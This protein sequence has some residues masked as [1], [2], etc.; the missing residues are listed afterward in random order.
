[1]INVIVEFV[2]I[3][4]KCCLT[5]LHPPSPS[6]S[7]SSFLFS[8]SLLL[9]KHN[10]THLITTKS[11]KRQTLSTVV[12]LCAL[13]PPSFLPSL[14]NHRWKVFCSSLSEDWVNVTSRVQFIG[15]IDILR[16]LLLSPFTFPFFLTP[17]RFPELVSLLITQ[18]KQEVELSVLQQEVC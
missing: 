1:M 10:L 18:P 14:H 17:T 3:G 13:V 2:S 16:L 11:L 7:T 8:L 6:P 5:S 12:T 15:G 4:F 9:S